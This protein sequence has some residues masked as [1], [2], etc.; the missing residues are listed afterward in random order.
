MWYERLRAAKPVWT[1]LTMACVCPWGPTCVQNVCVYYCSTYYKDVRVF[2]L[3]HKVWHIVLVLASITVVIRDLL[4]A[5]THERSTAGHG[6]RTAA[7]LTAALVPCSPR[8]TLWC[9]SLPPQSSGTYRNR[10]FFYIHWVQ[11][12]EQIKR[13]PAFFGS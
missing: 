8:P 9:W 1:S 5:R 6:A 7:S 13:L 3:A 11:A 12:G 10:I 2:Q 4:R